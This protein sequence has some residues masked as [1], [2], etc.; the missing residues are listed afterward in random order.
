MEHSADMPLWTRLY[1]QSHTASFFQSPRWAMIWQRYTDNQFHPAPLLGTL[2]SGRNILLPLSKARLA[3]G[4]VGWQHL[5]PAGTYGGWLAADGQPVQSEDLGD[6]LTMLGDTGI[7]TTF[8]W[9]PFS[10]GDQGSGETDVAPV[11]PAGSEHPCNTSGVLPSG[12]TARPEFTRVLDC[13]KGFGAIVHQWQSSRSAMMR[14]LRKAKQSGVQVRL[15]RSPED[16]RAYHTLYLKSARRWNPPPGHVYDARL[17]DI[18]AACEPECKLWLAEHRGRIVAGAVLLYGINHVAYWHGA[19]DV[20]QRGTR[21]VNLLLAKAIKDACEQGY[22]WFDFNPGGGVQGVDRF[23]ASFGAVNVACSVFE[24]QTLPA[25]LC[26]RI[27]QLRQRVGSK[28]G[29][30]VKTN[31]GDT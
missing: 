14:N 17:W 12:W 2:P 24:R 26:M 16:R 15:A 22:R 25:A 3:G 13:A 10:T 23:K 18:L 7:S 1:K 30:R 9:F 28:A 6:V 21:P 4:L 31:Q 19:S 8:R 20:E 29:R 11:A 27:S 5:S